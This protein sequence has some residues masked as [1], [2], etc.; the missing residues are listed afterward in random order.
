MAERSIKIATKRLHANPGLVFRS[1]FQVL[2]RVFGLAFATAIALVLLS[3]C[4]NA[5]LWRMTDRIA[6]SKAESLKD[7]ETE[8]LGSK[9]LVESLG[10]RVALVMVN[11]DSVSVELDD[12]GLSIQGERPPQGSLG[13]AVPVSDDGYFLTAA[14]IVDNAEKLH[15]VVGLS[16]SEG[17]V[18][19]K[20]VPARIVWMPKHFS[21][22]GEFNPPTKANQEMDFAIIHS[23]AGLLPPLVP[24]TLSGEDPRIDQSVMIVGWPILHFEDFRNGAR[25]AAGKIV[26][27]HRPDATGAAPVFVEVVHDAPLVMGDSGGPLLDRKGNLIGINSILAF[28]VSSWQYFAMLLGHRPGKLE[29]LGYFATAKIPDPEW[30]WEVIDQDRQRR[31]AGTA[32]S[33]PQPQGGIH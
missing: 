27:V 7:W 15:L 30:L 21:R 6:A 24:F 5:F 3:G 31:N 19:A 13:S 14:H 1:K 11:F 33:I 2:L 9:S 8:T 10:S 22:K 18:Q 29:E 32:T 20:G 25:L 17:R 23:V 16:E 4:A 12:S 26:S 28:K